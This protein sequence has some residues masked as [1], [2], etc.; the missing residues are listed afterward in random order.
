MLVGTMPIPI[1]I[2]KVVALNDIYILRNVYTLHTQLID[3]L[4]GLR[5]TGTNSLVIDDVE[6]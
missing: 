1:Q 5:K 6:A 2:S 4:E 3:P